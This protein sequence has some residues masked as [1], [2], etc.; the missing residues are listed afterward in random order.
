MSSVAHPVTDAKVFAYVEYIRSSLS[1]LRKQ[2]AHLAPSLKYVREKQ[3]DIYL[4]ESLTDVTKYYE[5]RSDSEPIRLDIK[6]RK[7][8]PFVVHMNRGKLT[9]VAYVS[10]SGK[11]QRR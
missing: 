7:D 11:R 2:L 3:E 5:P 6:N 8:E 1:A 4:A 10:P 9:Q